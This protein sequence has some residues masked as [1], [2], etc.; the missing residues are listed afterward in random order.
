M[1]INDNLVHYWDGRTDGSDAIGSNDLT[2]SGS[3]TFDPTKGLSQ[4]TQLD[5][6]DSASTYEIGTGDFT[7]CFWF[8]GS[9]VQNSVLDYIG[10]RGLGATGT[11]SG[12]ALGTLGTSSRHQF[13]VDVSGGDNAQ[14]TSSSTSLPVSGSVYFCAAVLDRTA[15]DILTYRQISTGSLTAAVSEGAAD[16][17]P[18]VKNFTGGSAIRIGGRPG[19]TSRNIKGYIGDIRIY[20]RALPLADLQT[21]FNAGRYGTPV[22]ESGT[23]ALHPLAQG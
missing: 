20:S 21:L 17:A 7:V 1:P 12:W 10:T 9:A 23:R 18:G 5:Y 8:E 15:D 19:T 22:N 13:L 14:N 4:P 6:F 16:V 2:A 3:A 11:A